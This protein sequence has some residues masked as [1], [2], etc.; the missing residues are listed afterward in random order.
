MIRYPKYIFKDDL[1]TAGL[2]YAC[3]RIIL[4]KIFMLCVLAFGSW[5]LLDISLAMHW[6]PSGLQHVPGDQPLPSFIY[7][8]QL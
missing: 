2:I 4:L 6:D 5:I 3:V 8:W 7:A 1:G